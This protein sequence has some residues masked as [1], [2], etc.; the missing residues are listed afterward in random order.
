MPQDL[1]AK[2]LG[3]VYLSTRTVFLLSELAYWNSSD[4]ADVIFER[5]QSSSP[6]HVPVGS[7]TFLAR[8][9]WQSVQEVKDSQ[10]RDITAIAQY[11]KGEF[12]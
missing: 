12:D 9:G 10:N 3:A 2:E 11:T 5:G 4:L 1:E 8:L 7:Q 6:T